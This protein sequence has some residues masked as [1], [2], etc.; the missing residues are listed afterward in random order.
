[1][2]SRKIQFFFVAGAFASSLMSM[3]GGASSS[4]TVEGGVARLRPAKPPIYALK[5][6]DVDG[7]TLSTADGHVT[8]LVVSKQTDIDKAR[9]V[10]NRVPEYCLG[11][12]TYRMITVI[13]FAKKQS[14][15]TRALLSGVARQRLD[16][17]AKRLQPRYLA[18]KLARNPRRD[19]YAVLDF[20]GAIAAKLAMPAGS[21]G[22]QVLVLG[23]KGEL[24]G[25]WMELPTAQQ[26]AAVVK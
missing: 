7:S 18:K 5:L 26:L 24:L 10:G 8:I 15:L 12:P 6:N 1:V 22:F 4:E 17:E 2:R 13:S 16:A 19:V 21:S 25:R 11:N 3:C 14:R 23:R 9:L 20:D